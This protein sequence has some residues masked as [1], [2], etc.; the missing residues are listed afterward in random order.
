MQNNIQE[1]QGIILII[2]SQ[3][4]VSAR[5]PIHRIAAQ[6]I[7]FI[8]GAFI[9]MIQDYYFQGQ[10]Y[11]I[12]YVGAIAIQFLFVIMMV[13]I[14]QIS[15]KTLIR[16]E[17]KE[18]I[19]SSQK[20]KNNINKKINIKYSKSRIY[21]QNISLL[22]KKTSNNIKNN[23]QNTMIIKNEI[24]NIFNNPNQI[25]QSIIF[26]IFIGYNILINFNDNIYTY[27][28]TTWAIEYKTMTDIENLGYIIYIGYP[29][30]QI[31]IAITLWIVLIGIISICKS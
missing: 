26:F 9:F 23:N 30:I 25:Q 5:N 2:S 6:V 4:V 31:Q 10:T 20:N 24:K 3:I 28:Y 19:T 27:I 7:V 13:E 18:I 22:F 1:V 16:Y 14:P 11:I 8:I 21:D 12:V 17:P 15:S 29:I